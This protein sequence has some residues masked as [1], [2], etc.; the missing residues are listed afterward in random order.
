MYPTQVSRRHRVPLSTV[1]TL[2]LLGT[3]RRLDVE[4]GI[5]SLVYPRVTL[6]LEFVDDRV[7]APV[8]VPNGVRVV[9]GLR[10]KV[11]LL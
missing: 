6:E 1:L 8:A 3:R 11:V 9:P 5:V 2:P 7:G 4:R 10:A